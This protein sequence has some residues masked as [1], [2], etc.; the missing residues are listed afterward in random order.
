MNENE[1]PRLVKGF[2]AMVFEDPIT[3]TK[4]EGAAKLVRVVDRDCGTFEGRTLQRW[5]VRF[6][7]SPTDI[8]EEYERTILD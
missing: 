5:A 8:D 7:N 6:V 2:T 1:R 4:P 3:E